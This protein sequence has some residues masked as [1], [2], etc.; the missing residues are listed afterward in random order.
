M[1]Q[2]NKQ[3][4]D[5]IGTDEEKNLLSIQEGDDDIRLV[6]DNSVSNYG[7]VL[8]SFAMHA[9]VYVLQSGNK[10]SWIT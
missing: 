1:K 2:P 9:Y 5:E 4:K 3:R 10:A 6:S 8:F 7:K